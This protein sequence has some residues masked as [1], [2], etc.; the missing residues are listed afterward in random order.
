M[1]Q[2]QEQLQ[3]A[4][5]NKD[6]NRAVKISQAMG[7][8]LRNLC[9]QADTNLGNTSSFLNGKLLSYSHKQQDKMWGVIGR[10]LEL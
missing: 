7:V 10:L 3:D 6:L 4:V 2:L 5:I 1:E 9:K 8:S